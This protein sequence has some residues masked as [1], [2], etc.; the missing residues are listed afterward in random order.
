[1]PDTTAKSALTGLSDWI[2]TFG[3]P[4]EIVSDNGTQFVNSLIQEFVQ[5]SGIRYTTIHA[6]SHEENGIIERANKEVNRHLR[7]MVYDSKIKEQWQIFLPFVQRILN[8]M[9]HTT[10]GVSPSQL[11]FGDALNHDTHFLIPPPTKTSDPVTYQDKIA[12]LL[13]GQKRLLELAQKNQID[14]DEFNLIKRIEGEPTYFPL[15]SYV[16][17]EYEQ[18]LGDVTMKPSKLHTQ[19][20]GPY[21]VVSRQGNVYTL[22]NL[23]TH[24]IIDFHI[25]LLRQFRYDNNYVIPQE[26]AQHDKDYFEIE[27]IISHKFKKNP[28]TLSNLELLIKYEGERDS[29]WQSWNSTFGANEK[30]HLYFRH[31][32]LARFIPKKFTW[33]KDHPEYQPPLRK[34]Q[35]PATKRQKK[36]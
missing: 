24:G 33:P 8:T 4:S 6:Y 15:N 21:R 13:E 25:K 14:M 32:Q 19:L 27:E 30:I 34:Q 36:K 17:A 11:L 31:N 35:L 23:V 12:I 9:V 1:M 16:L 26:V 3:C 18:K 7:G 29:K 5:V 22:E 28:K 2:C 20:H 10:L